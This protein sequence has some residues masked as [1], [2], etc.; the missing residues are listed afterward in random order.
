MKFLEPFA[1][2]LPAAAL[3]AISIAYALQTGPNA[4]VFII[5][6]VGLVILARQLVRLRALLIASRSGGH[7]DDRSV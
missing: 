5:G 3:V 6:F 1:W 4:G 2:L 7:N